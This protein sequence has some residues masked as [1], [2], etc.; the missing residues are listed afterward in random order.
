M[1]GRHPLSEQ[2]SS[3]H[4]LSQL[5]EEA[6]ATPSAD[7]PPSLPH[8]STHSLS[9]SPEP[10]LHDEQSFLS[11]NTVSNRYMYCMHMYICSLAVP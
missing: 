2:Q 1:G 10:T 8:L 6:V 9:P 3:H 7:I 4:D 11:L 5:L